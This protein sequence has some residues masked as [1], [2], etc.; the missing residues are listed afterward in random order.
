MLNCPVLSISLSQGRSLVRKESATYVSFH[1]V[2]PSPRR[3]MLDF[4][5]IMKKVGISNN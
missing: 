4:A 3:F 1:D 2:S 5:N